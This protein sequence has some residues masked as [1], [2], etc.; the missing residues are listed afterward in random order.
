MMNRSLVQTVAL[1]F[2]IVYLLVGILGLLPFVGGSYTQ[3][4]SNLLGFVPINLLHNIVHLVIGIA[5]I[6]AAASIARS[7]QFCQVFGVVLILI[8]IVGIFIANPLSAIPIGGFDVIIHLVTGG[9]LAYFGF[10]RAPQLR[11]VAA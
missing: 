1:A 6:A 7:R 5:G 8:G 2:G 3:T 10:V 11:P 4:N 9:I